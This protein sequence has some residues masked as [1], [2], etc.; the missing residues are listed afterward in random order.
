MKSCDRC[1]AEARIAA[2]LPS[3]ALLLFCQHHANKHESKLNELGAIIEPL[4]T[5]A[6]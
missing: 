3:G 1:A 4:D 5:M 2:M 6:V